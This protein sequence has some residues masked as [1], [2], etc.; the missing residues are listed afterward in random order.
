MAVMPP[1]G[2]RS[3]GRQNVNT[4]ARSLIRVA[5][6]VVGLLAVVTAVLGQD[7]RRDVRWRLVTVQSELDYLRAAKRPI[8][9]ELTQVTVKQAYDG[10]ASTSE[11]S[12]TYEGALNGDSKHDVSFKNMTL[13]DVLAKLGDTFKLS[14]RVDGPA[15]LTVIGAT[16][17][18]S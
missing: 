8:S 10:I 2:S 11:L 4:G 1:Q 9:I 13:K 17:K 14:Y 16:P 3:H 5:V 6:L 7:P 15:K 12:I 18:K